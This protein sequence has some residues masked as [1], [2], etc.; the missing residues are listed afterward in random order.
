MPRVVAASRQR[1]SISDG[2]VVAGRPSELEQAVASVSRRTPMPL[3]TS[4]GI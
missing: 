3:L 2:S 1:S 4:D